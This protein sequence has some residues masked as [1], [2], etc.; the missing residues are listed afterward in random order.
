MKLWYTLTETNTAGQCE[1]P[2]I[3][4]GRSS[5]AEV[6][7]DHEF[8]SR[9]HAALREDSGRFVIED[10]GSDNGTYVNGQRIDAAV[11]VGPGDCVRL[12]DPGP[13]IRLDRLEPAGEASGKPAGAV[14]ELSLKAAK[15]PAD[16]P[17]PFTPESVWGRLTPGQRSVA[18]PVEA[19]AKPLAKSAKDG[20]E[21][22]RSSKLTTWQRNGAMLGAAAAVL[23]LLIVGFWSVN[24][25]SLPQ[26]FQKVDPATVQ[27]HT[28]DSDGDEG[29]G[30]GFFIDPRGWIATNFHVAVGSTRIDV[31]LHDGTRV[32]V[33]GFV[34]ASPANDLAILKIDP[35]DGRVRT[36]RLCRN[37]DTP[38]PVGTDVCVVG[39]PLGLR[40]SLAAGTVSSHMSGRE[41]RQWA[42]DRGL[43]VD[44]LI[45]LHLQ[46]HVT[47]IQT[48][49]AIS[50]GN[51]GGPLLNRRGEV[52][53]VVTRSVGGEGTT[54]I[55][56]ASAVKHLKRLIDD[57]EGQ[58]HP[59]SDL[60]PGG[61]N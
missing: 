55:H 11:A 10:L 37:P 4:L 57:A 5:A 31:E 53:G 1:A 44:A 18:P 9:R 58:V 32:P 3:T 14:A 61:S 16:C 45:A 34:A 23:L 50:R 42:H 21:P 12:G 30:S 39:H 24:T 41:F 20:G 59:L 33:E 46:D 27:I 52:V 29:V 36:L 56:F 49:A 25:G 7:L 35:P 2:A 54:G 8:I 15:P 6:R 13:E 51:S 40:K 43:E 22:K 60:T 38:P 48:N 47:W 28:V 26:L 17:P 19:P